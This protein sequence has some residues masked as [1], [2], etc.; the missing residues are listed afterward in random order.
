MVGKTYLK[1]EEGV[2]GGAICS[3]LPLC[4]CAARMKVKGAA[5]VIA[6]AL[7]AIHGYNSKT[8]A[9]EFSL[10]PH[11]SKMC[12]TNEVSALAIQV[13]PGGLGWQIVAGYATGKVASFR[14]SPEGQWSCGF[15]AI[16]HKP[17][18]SVLTVACD[19]ACVTLCSGGQDTDITIWDSTTQE[20]SYRLTGHRGAVVSC[21]FIPKRDDVLVS[22]SADGLIKIWDLKVQQCVQTIV[23]SDTQ[24][25]SLLADEGGFRLFCG[26]R[27]NVLKIFDISALSSA[28]YGAA[29]VGNEVTAHSTA[30]RK[31]NKPATSLCFSLDGSYLAITS[32]R[33][34]EVFRVLSSDEVKKRALRKKK[35]RRD[36]SGAVL[37]DEADE[38]TATSAI[39]PLRIFFFDDK[40]RG[41]CFVP[42]PASTG[43]VKIAVSF[44]TNANQFYTTSVTESDV[45]GGLTLSLTD[46]VN[47]GSIEH[48]GHRSEIKRVLF[49]DDDSGLLSLSSESLRLWHV[50]VKADYDDTDEAYYGAKEANLFHHTRS[51]VVCAGSVSLVD[52]TCCAMLSEEVVCVGQAD[53][54]VMTVNVVGGIISSSDTAHVGSVKALA[55]R[56]DKSGFASIGTDRRL[57]LWD[58]VLLADKRTTGLSLSQE[59]ELAESPLFISF[60]PDKRL[61]AIGLQDHNIQLFYADSLKPFLS[62]FGHRLPP[63]D[64]SFSADGT[65]VAS[66]GM[67]KSL[68]FWGTDFGDCHRSIH[69]HDDYVTS[70]TFVGETHFVFTCSLD[71]TIK[72]WD[73]DN[74]TLIQLFRHH[75]QGLWSVAVNSNGTCVVSAGRDKCVR[76]LLRTEEIL[77][78]AE[79]EERR[80]Q[81]AMDEEDNRRA[82]AQRLDEKDVNVAAVG[83]RTL[84]SNTSAEH[85]MDALDLVSVE[86]QRQSN[87]EDTGSAPHP[88]LRNTTVW[89]YMWSVLDT[90]RP[91]E[92]RHALGSLTS[93]HVSALLRYLSEM[94][95]HGAI[96]NH[97]TAAKIILS[98]VTPAPGSTSGRAFA[99][100]SAQE[101]PLLAALTEGIVGRLDSQLGRMEYTTA[102]LRVIMQH[103]E[104][105]EKTLF[106]DVSKVQGFRKKF[107]RRED[108]QVASK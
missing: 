42:I 103:L 98:L 29:V 18:T 52:A 27:E 38:E 23:A 72:H 106:F 85:I 77:F 16:G 40:V 47:K 39:V 69:A 70:V 1:Y 60:S 7:E 58:L 91:S 20:A 11:E 31:T 30:P 82:A 25:T 33:S 17:D 15:H 80:A 78:P 6:P 67:D 19:S 26:L 49:N 5:T 61:L 41:L 9:L 62:L 24:V 86:L 21:R 53:G 87:P 59:V 96:L 14:L 43:E 56:P 84:G 32:N 57:L 71:G 10:I 22:G 4:L 37:D 50:S 79:E 54:A 99:T 3:S 101:L 90:V 76:L 35:R 89:G 55:R 68:R 8:G 65:L 95:K 74:W 107:H 73:G 45:A 102:A 66:V 108:P 46:L 13:L 63:V 51:S 100:I 12:A 34:T 48:G 81:E 105:K 93:T 94:L 92:L 88:L 64:A 36:A 2:R 104:E 75:Q 97:E 83:Q 44:A 28:G